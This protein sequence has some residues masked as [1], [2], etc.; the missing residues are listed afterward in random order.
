M[1]RNK[2]LITAS[3]TISFIEK[4]T[5]SKTERMNSPF[6][7]KQSIQSNVHV[8]GWSFE[9]LMAKQPTRVSPLRKKEIKLHPTSVARPNSHLTNFDRGMRSYLILT[10]FIM[11]SLSASKSNADLFGEPMVEILC[12][13][14]ASTK[15]SGS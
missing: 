10:L 2:T 12:V 4:I 6:K 7:S 13:S 11:Y 9:S 14:L 8:F 3:D 1:G 5:L 15:T